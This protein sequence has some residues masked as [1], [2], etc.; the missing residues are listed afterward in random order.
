MSCN[1]RE[2]SRL[3]KGSACPNRKSRSGCPHASESNKMTLKIKIRIIMSLFFFL[4]HWY[5]FDLLSDFIGFYGFLMAVRH[6]IKETRPSDILATRP[7]MS[8]FMA[9]FMV[10]Q[11][12]QTAVFRE[13]FYEKVTRIRDDVESCF[14]L[15]GWDPSTDC[16]PKT[17]ST[18]M[19]LSQIS[20]ISNN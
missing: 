18:L 17:D 7:G 20:Q 9:K 11:T 8:W 19:I 6:F 13:T 16:T 14:I 1:L 2:M 5:Q 15:N 3:R 12:T 4:R 10:T